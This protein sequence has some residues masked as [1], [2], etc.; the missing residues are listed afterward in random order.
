[1]LDAGIVDY[2]NLIPI[3]VFGNHISHN[4]GIASSFSGHFDEMLMINQPKP[5]LDGKRERGG[6]NS[7]VHIDNNFLSLQF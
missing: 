1:M 4:F 5:Y 2:G 6:N 7:P 3:A